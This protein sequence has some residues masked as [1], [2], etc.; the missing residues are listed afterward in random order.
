MRL[1]SQSGDHWRYQLNQQ[2]AE[3]LLGLVKQF[4]CTGMDPV[5]LSKT[6]EH[7]QAAEREQLLAESLAQHRQALKALAVNLLGKD[8]WRKSGTGRLLTLNSEAREIL[9]QI[10]N[11]IRVGCWRALGEPEPLEEP[12]TSRKQFAYHRMMD[13]AGY[14]EMKL[15]AAED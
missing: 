15:L 10:L 5:Q 2:E 9:L 8:K 12:I 14:F 6:D 13:L 3:I 7:P 1:A 4:P 11:D